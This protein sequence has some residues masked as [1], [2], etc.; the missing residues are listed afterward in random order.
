MKI[1]HF[2]TRL[3]LGGAQENTLFTVEDHLREFGDEVTLITGP[4]LGPE[5]T[6]V[7]RAEQSGC[8]LYV[9]P[10]SRRSINPW[11]EWRVYCRVKRLL[12]ELRPDILHT[13]SSKAGILGRR[14]AHV[15]GI[16]CVHTIHGAAFHYG[17]HPWAYRAYRWAE[18]WAEPYCDRI[19]SVAD[20]MTEQY[21][22]AGIGTPEKYVTI[23]SGFD[24]APLLAPPTRRAAIRAEWGCG[25][26]D[27][28]VGKIG[29]LFPLKGH[30]AILDVAE[31]VVAACPHVR[32]VFIGDGILRDRFQARIR[33]A[34]LDR[35]FLFTGL[36]PPTRIPELLQALDMVVHTSQWEGLARVLPQ[37]LIAGK[38]VIS[39]DID[40]AREVVLP[41]RTGLLVP[42]ND[43]A[44]LE[45]ALV[46][47]A[48]NPSQREQLG[49]TGRELFT[50]TFRHEHMSRRIREVY[51]AV[52]TQRAGMPVS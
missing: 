27:V 17:Q 18:K 12:R 7:P 5:G 21:L 48:G 35:H 30:E 42:R 29:R 34:G 51:R 44:A 43:L 45:R 50:E 26:E 20:A 33:A 49:L 13:H 8:R 10:E 4:G 37:A 16:P 25:P 41:G 23:Y 40:G 47:L 24:V 1:V 38:P 28:L 32:F 14:A 3:I 36:V 31:G 39:Y 22:S 11:R 9:L 2:I 19:I 6:L 52:L 15:L 46:E